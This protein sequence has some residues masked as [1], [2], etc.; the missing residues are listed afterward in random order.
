MT[1]FGDDAIGGDAATIDGGE[2]LSSAMPSMMLSP[3]LCA[4]A[5]GPVCYQFLP[6]LLH[7]WKGGESTCYCSLQPVVVVIDLLIVLQYFCARYF[8]SDHFSCS[9]P[10][11]I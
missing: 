1:C 6:I 10:A 4:E 2:M 7:Q 9:L 5:S 11:A 3:P 8:P